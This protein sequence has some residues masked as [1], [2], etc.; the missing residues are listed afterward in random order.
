LP[1]D[2]IFQSLDAF[3]PIT[4]RAP[5]VQVAEAQRREFFA[6]LHR[7]LRQGFAVHVFCNTEGE[8]QRF[9]EIWQELVE[10]REPRAESQTPHSTLDLR[11]S[12]HLG[13]LSRGFIH[14]E[15]KLVV[16]TDAEI[17]GRYKVQRPRR[18]K[19]PHAATS[20]SL[21][22]IDFTEFEEGDY[23]VHVQHGIGRFLGLQIFDQGAGLKKTEKS[24]RTSGQ[25]C[26]AIEYAS[27]DPAQPAPKLYV[28][29]SEAHLVSKYVG[30]GKARPPGQGQGAGRGGRARSRG[31]DVAHPG[32][33]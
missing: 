1:M 30:T 29:V 19:S 17:F 12:T 31:G 9:E 7:W 15:S 32:R 18:L 22:D 10:S 23:V 14:E 25:E 16:V 24:R 27:N 2:G 21:L 8:R 4:E 11:P 5:E 3:R 13:T 20:R 28:P 6:Q 33:A 26:L